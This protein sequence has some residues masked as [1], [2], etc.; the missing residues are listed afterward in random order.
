[1]ISA[2]GALWLMLRQSDRAISACHRALELDPGYP[3]AHRWLGGAYLLKGMYDEAASAFARPEAPAVA[4]GFLGYCYARSGRKPEARR[5]LRELERA[6]S[7]WLA[8]QTAALHL[9]L[10]DAD[11]ALD[12]LH[13]ACRARSPGVHWLKVEPIWDPLR[14]DPRF[15]AIL[16][17]MGLD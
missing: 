7:P 14:P 10:G 1:V 2:L 6:S 12:W 17:E 9:G 5:L 13:K 4:A 3:W 8:E 15:T 11:V 16:Q